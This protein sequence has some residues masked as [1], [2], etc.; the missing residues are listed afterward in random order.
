MQPAR[1]H[2]HRPPNPP[3]LAPTPPKPTQIHPPTPA[4]LPPTGNPLPNRQPATPP[5]AQPR[6]KEK[7]RSC[8]GAAGHVPET[9]LARWVP[10]ER[11]RAI[12]LTRVA[13]RRAWPSSARTGLPWVPQRFEHAR[14]SAP[15]PTFNPSLHPPRPHAQP[16]HQAQP[17]T[18]S[19]PVR[20]HTHTPQPDGTPQPILAY[21]VTTPAPHAGHRTRARRHTRPR[22]TPRPTRRPTRSR[23]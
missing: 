18:S 21:T 16:Q 6:W 17:Q 15:S 20:D 7:R 1:Q 11:L 12:P 19:T 10:S 5:R 9:P 13:A 4:H 3:Q 8:D 2:T 23:R 22:T 14:R